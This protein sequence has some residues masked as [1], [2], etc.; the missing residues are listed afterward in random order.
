M[1]GASNQALS[2]R[3][4][5]ILLAVAS[6]W[7]ANTLLSKIALGFV[8]PLAFLTAR[9]GL[10]LL[11]ACWLLRPL[12][13][14]RWPL[15][16][17]IALLTGPVHFGLQFVGIARAVDLSPM[18]IAMQLWIP[19]SVLFAAVALKET[20]APARLAGVTISFLGIA[21]LAF[22]PSVFAQLDALALVAAA[23]AS[24]AAASVLMARTGGLD[25]VQ[26]Q[27]W[28]AIASVPVLGGASAAVET[29]QLAALIAAP[30][31]VAVALVVAALF[32]GLL[33]NSAMW[34]II[35]R[36]PV[37]AVTPWLQV[38]PVVAIVLGIVVLDDPLT[39]QLI[40]G[41]ALSLA[42]VLVVAMARQA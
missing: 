6:T 24:Y 21:V 26:T 18:V 40:A 4:C 9:F 19:F 5:L 36:H 7:G 32:S 42:G 41:L 28:V 20:I 31:I 23:A 3:E 34:R 38:S 35:Q 10:T 30:P 33:A 15:L 17:V 12:R 13:G 29:G 22:E 37:S 1:S 27:L 25:P 39:V 16:L 8:P 2:A 14:A 11:L